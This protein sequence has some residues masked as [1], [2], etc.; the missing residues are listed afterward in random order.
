MPV[1][2][3]LD[4]ARAQDARAVGAKAARLAQ[5]RRRGLPVLP[6]V[7][8]PVDAGR[9]AIA[10]AAAALE[11]GGSG[12]ARLTAMEVEVDEALLAALSQESRRLGLPL[13][14]RSS[15]PLESG[16]VWAGAF[17]S[18][19]GVGP[20][21]L[22]TALRGVWASA[23]TVHALERCETTGTDPASLEL[24]VLVQP[25]V[26][27]VCGGS[28]RVLGD[29]TVAVHATK[30]SP[31]DLMGGWEVGVRARVSAD[32]HVDDA[33]AVA[34]LGSEPFRAAADLA[35]RVTTLLGD[36]LIEW[37]W[38][39]EDA[40]LLQTSALATA[41]ITEATASP[42][43][44]HPLALQVARLAQR[45]PG[46][47]GEGLVLPWAVSVPGF[48]PASGATPATAPDA[49]LA[50][51]AAASAELL[52]HA[53]QER[54]ERAREAAK[55]VFAELRGPDPGPALA[56]L[57][58]LRP[59]D[60]A[61]GERVVALLEGV[62]LTLA[63]LGRIRHPRRFWRRNRDAAEA[64]IRDFDPGEEPVRLGP[65][66][67][68][69]FVYGVV[70]AHGRVT[71]GVPVVPGVAAGRVVVVRNPHD[72][73]LVVDRD[74]IVTQRP[75]P[76]LSPL[77]WRASGLVTT[78]GNPAAH[79]MEVASSL[80]VPTVLGVDLET[81]DGLGRLGTSAC[82]AAVDGDEGLVAITEA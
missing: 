44:A 59:V 65:D 24:A 37:A 13:V 69:P 50:A 74:V 66:R 38:T 57:A 79:L 58:G 75:L 82:L 16:G 27:P 26:E 17:S 14:V 47:L 6:G 5:A 53:W 49:D 45:F 62:A 81:V 61:Q 11:R 32:G 52:K 63:T 18:F 46:P 70:R 19:E 64:S 72:P 35:R 15:S 76:A 25:Q 1:L 71:S 8:V 22:R 39:G 2:I 60:V 80:G 42:D 51:A 33:E 7:V 28:A 34:T 56:R 55:R 10:G 12:A 67:W 36:D 48:S 30:G 4:D 40:L 54:P 68:E 78:S 41:P 9:P 31:R 77:L 43:L 73:P 29:G 21:D 23:F 20:A 3:D